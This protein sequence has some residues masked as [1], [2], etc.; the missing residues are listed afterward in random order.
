MNS[1]FNDRR[2]CLGGTVSFIPL[3]DTLKRMRVGSVSPGLQPPT[4]SVPPRR[5]LAYLSDGRIL[6]WREP[7][8]QK[9]LMTLG[10]VVTVKPG[11]SQTLTLD[12]PP[13]L[14]DPRYAQ[15]TPQLGT[16]GL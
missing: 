9:Q 12:W 7:D 2:R 4:I 13:E 14:H 1:P 16:I 6:A 5:Y 8:V 3:S 11:E 15:P 10:K